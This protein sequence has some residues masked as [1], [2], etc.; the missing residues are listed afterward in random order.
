M[1]TLHPHQQ[2]LRV[3]LRLALRTHQSVLAFSPTGS[4]KTVLASALIRILMDAGKRVIFSVHRADLLKQTAGTFED[5]DI[6]YSYIAAGYRHNIYRKVNIA[7]IPT[8]QNR[9]GKYPADYMFVDEAHLSASSGWARTID[10]YR[11]AGTKIIGLTGSPERLDGK[12]LGDVWDTMV[13]GPSTRWLIE[14]G[15][16]SEY[17]AY[18]PAGVDL[19]GVR[20]RGGDYVAS[21]LDEVMAGKAV[22]AGAVRHW[23][24]YAAGKRTIAF[25]PSI[26]RS[27]Q[28]AAEFRANGIMAVHVDGNTAQE[29]RAKAFEAFADRKIDVLTNCLLWTEGFDLAAQVGRPC[30]V[31]CVLDYS[32]TQSLARHLQKHGRGLRKDGGDPHILLDLVGGF[33]R[34]GL[35]DDEREW[36]LEGRTKARRATA[37]QEEQARICPTCFAAHEP[38]PV[39][40]ECGH[41][42]EVKA[43]KVEEVEGELEE[44]DKEALRRQRA[45]EQSRAQTLDDL[46]RLA[47]ARGYK[48]P[49]RWAAHVF[50]ARQAKQRMAG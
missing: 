6:P 31:E 19:T 21:D 49:Q 22:M 9:L 38:R 14:N 18:A 13:L 46:V 25:A 10:F 24:K 50:T 12:P 35:P 33:A 11:A 28:L 4:G 32:P 43:R 37:D 40:P 34:L 41:V 44:I 45:V 29:D 26:A 1:I 36:S 30:T 2:Q 47:T 5:F 39:C 7:S 27:E 48:S 15:F 17:R 3:D 23:R 20:S 8:L 42:Y 16:L